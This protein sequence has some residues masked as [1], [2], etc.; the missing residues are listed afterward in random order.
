MA[1]PPRNRRLGIFAGAG[2]SVAAPAELPPGDEFHRLLLAGCWDAARNFAPDAVSASGLR[3][4]MT[5]GRRNILGC[6]EDCLPA[7]TTAGILDCMRVSVPTEAHLLCAVHAATGVPVITTNFDNGIELAHALLIGTTA[8]PPETPTAY[9]DLLARWRQ[10]IP[11]RSPLRVVSAPAQLARRDDLASCPTLVKLRGSVDRGTDSTVIPL[12]PALEDM[13]S[14]RLD[15]DRFAA[16]CAVAERGHLVVTGHSGRDLDCFESLRLLLRPGRFTWVAPELEPAV[17]AR[18]ADIDPGQPR[19]GTAE[20]LLRS[21]LPDLPMWPRTE[22]HGTRFATRFAAWWAGLPPAATAEA[23]AW[24]LADAGRF[25]EPMAVIRGLLRSADCARLRL[26][27][28]E[29]LLQRGHPLDLADADRIFAGV[30]EDRQAYPRFYVETRRLEACPDSP[31]PA[32]VRTLEHVTTRLTD[33]QAPSGDDVVGRSAIRCV[34]ILSRLVRDRVDDVGAVATPEE[35]LSATRRSLEFARE[36][37][38]QLGIGARQSDLELEIVA[39]AA[40][41]ALYGGPPLSHDA[42]DRVAAVERAY[43]HRGDAVR[44][45][46]AVAVRALGCLAR[47]DP[48]S[49]AEAGTMLLRLGAGQE[50]AHLTE[51]LWARLLRVVAV[52]VAEGKRS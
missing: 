19:R 47:G 36:W 41:A 38:D 8:L 29:V 1:R 5:T 22:V 50:Y 37:A 35:L 11:D 17:V 33:R 24:M 2:V 12:R 44:A 9:H 13:E 21:L 7:G 51:H 6:I 43:A 14:T 20:A 4:L 34:T 48:A 16:L 30:L 39:V 28:A 31:L 26:R 23:Y 49:A 18:I 46:R 32:L 40:L 42:S 10:R 25:E 52:P 45:V 3:L 27:L 15:E